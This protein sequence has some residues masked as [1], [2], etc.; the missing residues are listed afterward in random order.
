MPR[1]PFIHSLDLMTHVGSEASHL[2][3]CLLS[4]AT[5]T[6]SGNAQLHQC[7]MSSDHLLLVFHEVDHLHPSSLSSLVIH[8]A[9]V[10]K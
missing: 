8:R 7:I 1:Q 3:H 5:W 2:L 10:S 6:A 4:N 9:N